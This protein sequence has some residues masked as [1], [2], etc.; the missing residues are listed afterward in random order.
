MN[1]Q[2]NE[3]EQTE[4]IIQSEPQPIAV[5]I[6]NNE[7]VD[8]KQ[9]EFFDQYDLLVRKMKEAL[10]LFP[11]PP[12]RLMKSWL[13]F[14]KH[15][16]TSVLFIVLGIIIGI[17]IEKFMNYNDM[18]RAVNIQRMEF[19]GDLFEVQPS[20]IKKYYNGGEKNLS[21]IIPAMKKQEDVNIE[22][23]SNTEK[24]EK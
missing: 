4:E 24:K 5:T 22:V 20:T 13:W 7:S 8:Q 21:S 15:A 2:I 17:G 11:K 23:E 9:K 16:F 14:Q 3:K 19:K 10:D 12:G 18:I 1:D 6:V